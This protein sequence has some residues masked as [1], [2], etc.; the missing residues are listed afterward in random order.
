MLFYD[1]ALASDRRHRANRIVDVNLG[2]N[3]GK[4][5]QRAVDDLQRD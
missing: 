5:S 3:G 2:S 4:D 1:R